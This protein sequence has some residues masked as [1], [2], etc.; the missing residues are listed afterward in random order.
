[1]FVI[2]IHPYKQLTTLIFIHKINETK[3]K[4][5]SI[6]KMNITT[7]FFFQEKD[8]QF[9][10]LPSLKKFEEITYRFACH[11]CVKNCKH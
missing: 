4:K 9:L 3:L 5:G 7:F 1:M 8:C 2:E 6:I 10:T 11:F